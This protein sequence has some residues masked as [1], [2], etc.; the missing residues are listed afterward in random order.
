[1]DLILVRH[2]ETYDNFNNFYSGK[3]DCSLSEKGIVETKKLKPFIERYNINYCI[4]S[5]LK[6]AIE[7]ANILFNGEINID[8]RIREMDFGIF[9]GL[10]YEEALEKYPVEVNSWNDDYIN[11]KISEGESLIEVY[12]RC[13]DFLEDIQKHKGN[14]LVVTHGGVIRCILSYVFGNPKFFFKFKVDNSS[15]TILENSD[16]YYFLK[17]LN[18]KFFKGSV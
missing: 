15:I 13:T 10:T 9:E 17:G 14:V 2:G 11:Y 16:E 8:E 1:M 3:S 18:I 7:T 4:S 6:R 5:P 12:E